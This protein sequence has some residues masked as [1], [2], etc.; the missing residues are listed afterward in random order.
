MFSWT[1]NGQLIKNSN[2]VSIGKF[3]KKTSVLNIDY[4]SEK[5]AGNYSCLA[6][7]QAGITSYSSELIVNG[8][9]I[10]IFSSFH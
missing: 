4:V 9:F 3:G 6:S 5:H 2:D 10:I 7:N 8:S 1:L